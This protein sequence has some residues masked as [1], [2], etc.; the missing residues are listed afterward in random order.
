MQISVVN[1]ER[2]PTDHRSAGF[3]SVAVYE[4][5]TGG[6]TAGH[7]FRLRAT[8]N[9]MTVERGAPCAAWVGIGRHS[10]RVGS[11]PW[12]PG[13]A[14]NDEPGRDHDIEVVRSTVVESI[15][16]RGDGVLGEF[17]GVL[18]HGGEV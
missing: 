1:A 14:S 9:G 13:C 11:V 16:E 5:S 3:S 7:C 17:A 6:C 8:H 15:D 2:E 18:A 12:R 10:P 4:R